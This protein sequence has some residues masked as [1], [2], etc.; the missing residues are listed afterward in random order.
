MLVELALSVC[1]VTAPLAPTL[2]DGVDAER[3]ERARAELKE[4]FQKGDAEARL[5]AIADHR[6]VADEK[7]IET[8]AK[9]MDDED[10]R[11]AI[12]SIDALR[13]A[14]HPAALEELHKACKRDKKL[15]KDE[16]LGPRLFKAIAWHGDPSS[17]E[18]LADDPFSTKGADFVRARIFGLGRIR[19]PKAV[20]ALMDMMNKVGRNKVDDWM[21]DFRLS[22]VVLTGADEGKSVEGWTRWWND[23]KKD[24]EVSPEPPELPRLMQV[25][26]NDYWDIRTEYERDERR[27]ERGGKRTGSGDRDA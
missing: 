14:E 10:Q 26:W 9:G 11:V 16:A 13:Y 12:A 2:Q 15:R 18:L 23:H 5:K 17:V 24:L 1:A 7:V 27:E 25:R 4:A 20:E 22:L 6:L 19:D 21:D 3:V 8:I